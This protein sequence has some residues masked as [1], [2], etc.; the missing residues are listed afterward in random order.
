MGHPDSSPPLIPYI[1]VR[2]VIYLRNE[3][4]YVYIE[5]LHLIVDQLFGEIDIYYLIFEVFA[6]FFV[7]PTRIQRKLPW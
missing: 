3:S 7:S 6:S 2:E 5:I 1:Q 4:N